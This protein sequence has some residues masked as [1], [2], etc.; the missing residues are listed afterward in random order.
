MRATFAA[1][2]AF[3][4]SLVALPAQAHPG[5]HAHADVSHLLT[6]PDHLLI[7]GMIAAIL[8][9]PVTRL[10]LRRVRK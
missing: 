3:A 6:S 7:L 10:A 5:D 4:A 9:L 8:V 2:T 1:A